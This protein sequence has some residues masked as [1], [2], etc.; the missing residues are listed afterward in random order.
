MD[1]R[2]QSLIKSLRAEQKPE[3]PPEAASIEYARQLDAQD[4]LSFLRDNFIIPSRSSLKKKA[5]NDSVS[6]IMA[7]FL[8]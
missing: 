2:F 1:S 7:V 3:F 8:S 6:G 5:L 4:T